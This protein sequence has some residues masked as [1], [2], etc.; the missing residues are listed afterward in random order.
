MGFTALYHRYSALLNPEF[1]PY[2]QFYFRGM[3]NVNLSIDYKYRFANLILFGEEAR[4][5]N[6]GIALLNGVQARVNSQLNVSVISR[7]YERNYQAMFG[8]SFGENTRNNNEAGVFA[9]FESHPI[10]Y[11][12][13]SG[14]M[15]IF[16]F[17]WLTYGVD[18]PSNGKEYLAQLGFNPSDKVQMYLQYRN[19]RKDD[20]YSAE[21]AF[22]NQVVQVV[23]QRV[24]YNISFAASDNIQLHSRV[25]WT[26]YKSEFL[27][28][29]SGFYV[30]QDVEF[31]FPKIPMK[32]YLRYALFDTDGYNPRIYAY[33]SDLL[34]TFSIPALYD[35]GSRSYA[36][37]KYSVGKRVDI[38][39]KY[40]I[41]Q[42]A[43][44]ETVGTGL[45]E[46]TGNQRSEV[47]VQVL[48]KI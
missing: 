45:Y 8:S 2:N 9:G 7:Y 12:V 43:D 25:E 10:K 29:G 39:L 35:R 16:R 4:S 5:Q 19:K 31:S 17:P 18:M 3:S 41:T 28:P 1:Q 32:V 6:G 48:V 38:W 46:S 47:K 11:F 23:T 27:S 20:N 34:Y 30:G 22:K 13:L 14:Y 37:I 36:M 40:G 21:T 26:Q 42:Y 33:E 15:D 44:K 24:R